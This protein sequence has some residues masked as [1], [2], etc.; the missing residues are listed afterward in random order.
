MLSSR[1]HYS[2]TLVVVLAALSASPLLLGAEGHVAAGASPAPT[3]P[4]RPPSRTPPRKP[5]LA[6][7]P[8]QTP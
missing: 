7:L 1:S 8:H 5:A 2:M 3:T 4:A 6:G